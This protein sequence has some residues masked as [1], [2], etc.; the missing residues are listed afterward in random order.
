MT[1][2]KNLDYT[3]DLSQEEVAIYL[4][5]ITLQ[6]KQ[7]SLFKKSITLYKGLVLPNQFELSV[8]RRHQLIRLYGV[9]AMQSSNSVRLKLR[10]GIVW[11]NLIIMGLVFTSV[12]VVLFLLSVLLV[13]ENTLQGASTFIIALTLAYGLFR[14]LIG[15]LKE[16][17]AKNSSD[18]I[19]LLS[20]S[21]L[22]KSQTCTPISPE[23]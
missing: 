21:A 2:F 1:Y 8:N 18:L 19:H 16:N 5:T 9:V 23:N 12:V 7:R 14:S 10:G 15:R 4:T 3:I 11:R 20:I 22:M 6:K 13:Q 17:Y